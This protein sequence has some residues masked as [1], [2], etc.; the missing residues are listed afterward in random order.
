MEVLLS[1]LD[2]FRIFVYQTKDVLKFILCHI[3]NLNKKHLIPNRFFGSLHKRDFN[4]LLHSEVN[5][6]SSG[7]VMSSTKTASYIS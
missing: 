6:K 1:F 7:Y 4:R 2:N 3:K 5:Y